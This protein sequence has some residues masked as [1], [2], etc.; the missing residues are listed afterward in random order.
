[1]GR[2]GLGLCVLGQG[3]PL[4]SVVCLFVCVCVRVCACVCAVTVCVCGGGKLCRMSRCIRVF[5]CVDVVVR[6]TGLQEAVFI[7]VTVGVTQAVLLRLHLTINTQLE[8]PLAGFKTMHI[9]I[10]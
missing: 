6:T 8:L 1:M 10:I 2:G 5:P 7:S 3:H 9:T 4:V